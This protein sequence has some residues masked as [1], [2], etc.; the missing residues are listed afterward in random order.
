MKDNTIIIYSDGGARGNPGPAA[1]G[2]LILDEK[3]EVLVEKGVYLEENLTNNQAE[4]QSLILALTEAKKNALAKNI[5]VFLDSELLVNQLKGLY[6]VK[7]K[8]LKTL[9]DKTKELILGFSSVEFCHIPREKNKRAD[10]LVN[11]VLNER[12]TVA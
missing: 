9:F 7:D 8:I 11:K 2:F 10:N 5:R 4:Y 6:R 1:A 3:N 12:N